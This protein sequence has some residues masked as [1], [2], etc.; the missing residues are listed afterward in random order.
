MCEDNAALVEKPIDAELDAGSDNP[1]ERS[2]V[3]VDR[4]GD[5]KGMIGSERCPRESVERGRCRSEKRGDE[6]MEE[7]P[8]WNDIVLLDITHQHAGVE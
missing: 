6:E 1:A 5:Q 3:V 4:V 7:G 8:E 2:I